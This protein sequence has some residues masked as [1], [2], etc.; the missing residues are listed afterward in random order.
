MST[1]PRKGIPIDFDA[2]S[3][4]GWK[5]NL[6][7][8]SDAA[9]QKAHSLRADQWPPGG[10]PLAA[11][12]FPGFLGVSPADL[13]FP[14]VFFVVLCRLAGAAGS[15]AGFPETGLYTTHI[16]PRR[17]ALS[18]RLFQRRSLSA[19]TAK[20]SATVRTVSPLRTL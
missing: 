12:F 4:A 9:G 5:K 6:H 2:D 17:R 13:A 11:C 19:G 8:A 10:V 15:A 3:G 1:L 16:L 7:I 14:L 20:S 18:F